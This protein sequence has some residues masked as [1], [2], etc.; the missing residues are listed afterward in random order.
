MGVRCFMKFHENSIVERNISEL[1]GKRFAVDFLCQIYKYCIAIRRN[2]DDLRNQ[3]KE[4]VSHLHAI[5]RTVDFFTNICC[6]P[7][8]V[9]DGKPPETKQHTQD[10]RNKKKKRAQEKADNIDDK[11]SD[12]YI[13]QYKRSFTPKPQKTAECLELLYYMGLPFIRAINEADPQCAVL[14][15]HPDFCGVVSKD[16]DIALLGSKKQY[17]EFST[18][19][20]TVKEISMGK[21]LENLTIKANAILTELNRKTIDT[22]THEYLIDFSILMGTDYSPQIKGLTKQQLFEYFVFNDFNVPKTI[23]YIDKERENNR[24]IYVPNNFLTKWKDAKAYYMDAKVFDPEGIDINMR[25]PDK[26]KI[27]ELLCVK[28][29]FKEEEVEELIL[30]LE[31]MYDIYNMKTNKN[32]THKQDIVL[33]RMMDDYQFKYTKNRRKNYLTFIPKTN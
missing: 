13:R 3:N 32:P 23:D 12:E 4:S 21:I 6:L 1:V 5:C 33:K 8:F 15:C 16:S 20:N 25:R 27:H 11:T 19:N 30:K 9:V 17:I 10:N 18:Y 14:S 29:N 2:G 28:N 26:K 24:S 7:F 22:F 31:K